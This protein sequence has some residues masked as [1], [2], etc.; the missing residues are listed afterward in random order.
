MQGDTNAPPKG[1]TE[2]NVPVSAS[3]GPESELAKNVEVTLS[4]LTELA[5]SIRKSGTRY[6]DSRAEQFGK[7]DSN[8]QKTRAETYDFLTSI[9]LS[10]IFKECQSTTESLA[11]EVNFKTPVIERLVDCNMKRWN[12][13]LYARHH[14]KTLS[15]VPSAENAP[16][17]ETRIDTGTDRTSGQILPEISQ[18]ISEGVVGTPTSMGPEATV[19]S[20]LSTAATPIGKEALEVTLAPVIEDPS[21]APAPNVAG[22]F[23]AGR[24][25]LKYP[26]PPKTDA[27]SKYFQCSCCRQLLP[28]EFAERENWRFAFLFP[29]PKGQV[30]TNALMAQEAC[31]SRSQA[32]CLPDG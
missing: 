30:L 31:Q 13:F 21:E 26:K 10:G 23:V 25:R 16:N 11:R 28:I 18:T 19:I 6:R 7:N 4:Y 8:F 32:I 9:R 15:A 24:L 5:I 20:K 2:I 17:L 29:S 27:S 22:S 3:K 12:R 14:D 1:T